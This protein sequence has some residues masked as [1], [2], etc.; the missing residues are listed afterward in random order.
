MEGRR[1]I[2]RQNISRARQTKNWCAGSF[3][4]PPACAG[5]HPT[6]FLFGF[7]ADALNS[8]FSL[9]S[10]I[11]QRAAGGASESLQGSS[12]ASRPRQLLKVSQT[13]RLLRVCKNLQ[14][15]SRAC[16]GLQLQGLGPWFG[17][18]FRI[19]GNFSIQERP[20]QFTVKGKNPG[21]SSC[22]STWTHIVQTV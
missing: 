12:R 8:H 11:K 20:G 19:L 16:K 22:R 1:H 13:A 15:P 21:R 18:E 14:G 2:W 10:H 17:S 9:N 7:R 3:F 5:I 6:L 4:P